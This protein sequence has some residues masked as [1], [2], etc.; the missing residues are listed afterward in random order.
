MGIYEKWGEGG[1]D[2][3]QETAD[4]IQPWC[5]VCN[6]MN[7]MLYGC[8]MTCKT[9]STS[10]IFFENASVISVFPQMITSSNIN[11]FCVTGPWW[12]DS[13]GHRWIPLSRARDAELWCRLICAWTNGWANNR[14]ASDLRRHRADYN[15]TV[16]TNGQWCYLAVPNIRMEIYMAPALPDIVIDRKCLQ[17]VSADFDAIVN[18][19]LSK[20]F[21]VFKQ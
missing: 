20:Q 13:I 5:V 16:M 8:F 7:Q 15:Q 19:F 9:L 14:N 12:G 11:I 3:W 1:T 18:W 21:H 10:L 6:V 17:C 2:K 4:K